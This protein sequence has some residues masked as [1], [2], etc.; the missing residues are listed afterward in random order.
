MVL[1]CLYSLPQ[2]QLYCS[3]MSVHSESVLSNIS[4]TFPI[5][6]Q[7]HSN[8]KY[9]NAA[10]HYFPIW[11]ISPV[12]SSD[13]L[14]IVKRQKLLIWNVE[15]EGKL[16]RIK[17]DAVKQTFLVFEDKFYKGKRGSTQL[18]CVTWSQ[19]E[20]LIEKCGFW[21]SQTNPWLKLEILDEKFMS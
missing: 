14:K 15:K 8:W 20:V 11:S 2:A 4:E 9:E 6:W 10:L 21:T 12:I 5:H 19:N 16:I 13:I 7:E 18:Y 1:K 17:L 3:W